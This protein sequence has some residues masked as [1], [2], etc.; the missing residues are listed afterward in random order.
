MSNRW[1]SLPHIAYRD[2]VDA[3]VEY[4]TSCGKGAPGKIRAFQDE[5]G[6]VLIEIDIEVPADEDVEHYQPRPGIMSD[7]ATLRPHPNPRKAAWI[8]GDPA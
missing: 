6:L 2:L 4:E 8:L 1:I 5:D 7:F 3:S